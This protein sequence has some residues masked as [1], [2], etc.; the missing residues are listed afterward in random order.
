MVTEAPQLPCDPF[1]RTALLNTLSPIY[2]DPPYLSIL[3]LT[4]N[5]TTIGKKWTELLLLDTMHLAIRSWRGLLRN[6]IRSCANFS[7]N[8]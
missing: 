5:L 2:P 7:I 3:N 4:L 6:M 1:M 8:A